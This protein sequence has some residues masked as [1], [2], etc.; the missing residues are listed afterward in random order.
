M[1]SIVGRAAY[2]FLLSDPRGA[3][4]KVLDADIR[5]DFGKIAIANDG[6]RSML[7]GFDEDCFASGPLSGQNIGRPVAHHVR[8]LEIDFEVARG[9]YK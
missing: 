8:L 5:N 3:M 6:S 4:L 7:T 2:C 9:P 1:L